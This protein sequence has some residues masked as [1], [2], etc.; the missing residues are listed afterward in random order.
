MM[1]FCPS[2]WAEFDRDYECCPSC[3][4]EIKKLSESQDFIDKLI[5]ALHHPEPETP[6]RAA[7]ILGHLRDKRA[8]GPLYEVAQ[9]T[10]DTFLRVATINALLEVGTYEAKEL[11]KLCLHGASEMERRMVTSTLKRANGPRTRERTDGEE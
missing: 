1:F 9:E 3:G 7:W 4:F 8:I 10:S 2:C 5:A 6:I 11:A